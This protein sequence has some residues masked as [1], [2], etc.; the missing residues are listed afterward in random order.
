[1]F[2]I[3]ILVGAVCI[4]SVSTFAQ[5]I[6]FSPDEPLT[7]NPVQELSVE[8][9]RSRF[10]EAVNRFSAMDLESDRKLSLMPQSVLNWSNPE[11]NT[12]AGGLYFWTKQ[13]RPVIALCVYP[14]EGDFDFEFQSL[15]DQSLA[16]TRD[17]TS[18]WKP[19]EPGIVWRPLDGEK[20]TPHKSPLVRRRQMRQIANEFTARLVPP[21]RTAKPLRLQ[22][23]PVYRYPAD[24]L[25]AKCIDGGV[26]CFVQGTDPELLLMLEVINNESGSP[27][28]RYAVARMTMVPMQV[29]W[30]TDLVFEVDWARQSY[31]GPYCV[32]KQ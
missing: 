5:P 18:V 11:R 28:Y 4:T 14:N 23:A 12:L 29:H 20:W 25:P 1:M 26:F 16:V 17:N 24:K 19:T 15:T 27:I 7:Q 9:M 3:S 2:R 30:K 31:S 8:Q 6:S 21:N 32:I 10:A 22:S 13:S